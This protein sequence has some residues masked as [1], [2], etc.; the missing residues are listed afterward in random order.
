VQS[1]HVENGS[2]NRVAAIQPT[3]QIEHGS[4]SPLNSSTTPS[5][6]HG[7]LSRRI[8]ASEGAPSTPRLPLQELE[9][10][11]ASQRL[12]VSPGP[13][14]PS[15]GGPGGQGQACQRSPGLSPSSLL[16]TQ[17]PLD[18]LISP[19]NRPSVRE[20]RQQLNTERQ[21]EDLKQQVEALGSMVTAR[22]YRAGAAADRNLQRRVDDLE[23][24]REELLDTLEE[25]D[26]KLQILHNSV[27]ALNNE[28]LSDIK[29][30]KEEIRHLTDDVKQREESRRKCESEILDEK[31]RYRTLEN[32]YRNAL[33]ALKRLKTFMN[34]LPAP[35]EL[36]SL[37]LKVE[38][39]NE[40]KTQLQIKC[41]KL[42]DLVESARSEQKHSDEKC[43]MLE[44]KVNEQEE[45]NKELTSKLGAYEKRRIEARSLGEDKVESILIEKEDLRQE[46]EKL[47]NLLEWNSK[48]FNEEKHKREQQI[49]HYSKAIES[50]QIQMKNSL[51][52]TKIA[53]KEKAN[54][55]TKLADKEGQLVQA[56]NELERLR[57]E[58]S[59]L[60]STNEGSTRMDGQYCRLA[61]SMGDCVT[62]LG[63]LSELIEQVIDGKGDPNMSLLLG[64]REVVPA[65][66]PALF[67]QDLRTLTVKEK[68]TL[69]GA[70]EKEVRVVKAKAE[71]LRKKIA[72]KYSDQ[73]SYN[74][75]CTTQ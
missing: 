4:L 52:K 14:L 70:Q 5:T 11:A 48:K 53:D 73:I 36:E 35:E 64:V 41:S 75:S 66:P 2:T 6:H 51:M 8:Q 7:R 46:N 57:N 19:T 20:R 12:F 67:S 47:R 9:H 13:D 49:V 29:N 68:V 16:L 25:R 18:S 15:T 31:E 23:L 27:A 30:L 56:E 50:A 45:T 74:N 59:D 17:H 3:P 33:K 43:L 55:Q 22:Q 37:K 28:Y 1:E 38:T 42:S 32:E 44:V 61:R 62:R 26:K 69:L 10:L 72:E 71:D 24:E 63:N 58:V 60:S 54:L 34:S 40:E 21:I 65:N 39:A